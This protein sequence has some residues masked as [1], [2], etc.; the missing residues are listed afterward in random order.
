MTS[1]W[2]CRAACC[3]DICS[4]R[5]ALPSRSLTAAVPISLREEGN[6]EA[7]NQA[8]GMVCS[9]ASNIEDPKERLQKI[10]EKSAKSKEMSHP[11]RALMPQVSNLSFLGAPV[12]VQILALLYSRSDLSDVLPPSSNFTNSNV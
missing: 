1:S 8:F 9:L 3:A 10:I 5:G 2:R 7:N 11:L 12:L 4:K 6:A